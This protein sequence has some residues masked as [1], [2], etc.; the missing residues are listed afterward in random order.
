MVLESGTFSPGFNLIGL[1][2]P[3]EAGMG[4]TE[5]D[6]ASVAG[7]SGND[8]G[9]PS[10]L[11]FSNGTCFAKL[12]VVDSGAAEDRAEACFSLCLGTLAA[13]AAVDESGVTPDM[14]AAPAS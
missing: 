1:L 4:F 13:R 7:V 8:P 9:T 5:N 12:A 10:L 11:L 14:T 2:A 6:S 3:L